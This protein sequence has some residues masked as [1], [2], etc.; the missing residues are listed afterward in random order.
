MTKTKRF[1]IAWTNSDLTEGRGY[2]YPLAISE[3]RACAIRLG[4]KGSTMGCDCYV[5]AFDAPYVEG[6]YLF[7]SLI[8][9]SSSLDD[10]ADVKY[11]A[12]QKAIAAAKAAGLDDK[13]IENLSA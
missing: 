9:T 3:S 13:T 2:T 11:E 10:A 7:P 1:W 6:R 4:Y 8:H 12:R 5:E